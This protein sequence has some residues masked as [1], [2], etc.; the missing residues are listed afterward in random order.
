M[1]RKTKGY[2]RNCS[3]F[4]NKVLQAIRSEATKVFEAMQK[5]NE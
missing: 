4:A 5:Q 1:F 3:A 2:S